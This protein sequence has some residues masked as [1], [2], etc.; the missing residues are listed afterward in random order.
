MQIKKENEELKIILD[1][2]LETHNELLD[3][4]RVYLMSLERP[5]LRKSS[6]MQSQVHRL[7]S[8]HIQIIVQGNLLG[9][10]GLYWAIGYLF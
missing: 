6:I 1:K 2:V 7:L 4:S 3:I 10:E 5:Q 8:H 9:N